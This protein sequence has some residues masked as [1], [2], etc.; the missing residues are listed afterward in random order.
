MSK[1]NPATLLELTAEISK[2][3][4]QAAKLKV[5]ERAAVIARIKEAIPIYDITA[6]DLG[7]GKVPKAGKRG[8]KAKAAK[9]AKRA[10][11]KAAP[12]VKF[13]DEAGNVWS[14]RGPRPAWLRKALEGGASLESFAVLP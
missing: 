10:G 3:Q 8:P 4:A 11:K 13:K 6:A 1:K 14:G 5:S 2:L 7:F 9:P 12:T